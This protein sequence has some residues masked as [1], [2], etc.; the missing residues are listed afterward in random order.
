MAE[1][2][3]NNI[4]FVFEPKEKVYV[5]IERVRKV[6]IGT[7]FKSV[8]HC[9]YNIHV[10]ILIVYSNKLD[11]QQCSTKLGTHSHF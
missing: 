8:C 6:D 5:S 3:P 4:V 10:V 9:F 7:G 11:K 2:R 1:T